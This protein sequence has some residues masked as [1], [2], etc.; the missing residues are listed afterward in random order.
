MAYELDQLLEA[1]IAKHCPPEFFVVKNAKEYTLTAT[2]L[3]AA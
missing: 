3:E 2:D 1:W